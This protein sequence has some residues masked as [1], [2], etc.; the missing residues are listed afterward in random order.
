[1]KYFIILI[2]LLLLSALFIIIKEK[3]Y[4]GDGLQAPEF[5]DKVSQNAAQD[6]KKKIGKKG[7]IIFD[8]SGL[9]CSSVSDSLLLPNLYR[10]SKTSASYENTFNL[11]PDRI[12]SLKSFIE[13]VPP[14]KIFDEKEPY[15]N[16]KKI[17][18]D[19]LRNSS[20]PEVYENAGYSVKFFSS[21]T[22]LYRETKKYFSTSFLAGSKKQMI[23]T[24]YREIGTDSASEFIYFADMGNNK[25]GADYLKNTDLLIGELIRITKDALEVEPLYL[26]IST[27]SD[28]SYSPCLSLFYKKDIETSSDTTFV[29]ITDIGK[30]L[31]NFSSVR[32]P[33]YFGGYDIDN[34]DVGALREYF[35]GSVQDTLLLFDENFV[36]KSIKYS[37]KYSYYDIKERKDATGENLRI[38]EKYEESM[39]RYFGGDYVKYVI[40]KNNTEQNREFKINLRSRRRFE[41]LTSLNNYYAQTTKYY[42]YTKDINREVGAGKSDTVKIY[43]AS[44][45]QDFLFKFDS[46]YNVSYGAS[47]INAGN[48][49]SFDENSYYGL[50]FTGANE[51]VFDDYDIRIYNL[52]VNF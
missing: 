30:T 20:L 1:M 6:T 45:Y 38:N 22:I 4:D 29:S 36:Y 11:S 17:I 33:N 12:T 19:S 28:S 51:T 7:V 5:I 43:Y 25:D 8:I 49:D 42:R 32:Y 9:S 14:Y 21:D 47:G 48:V 44:M 26:F 3:A 13:C 52:R 37:P 18:A 39:S 31:L 27:L 41:E 23:E 40:L 34:F 16:Y 10:I 15:L 24:I 35:A 46:K 50:R 2:L